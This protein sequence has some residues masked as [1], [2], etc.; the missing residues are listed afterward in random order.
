MLHLR[1]SRYAP[2]ITKNYFARPHFCC[3]CFCFLLPDFCLCCFSYAVKMWHKSA[4]V[5]LIA[6]YVDFHPFLEFSITHLLIVQD[7]FPI[8]HFYLNFSHFLLMY[9]KLKDD[10]SKSCASVIDF[11]EILI[12]FYSLRL[13]HWKCLFAVCYMLFSIWILSS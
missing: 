10:I 1:Y 8:L 3:C 12:S 7:L 6:T 2:A 11:S 13:D 4:V 9:F 5:L